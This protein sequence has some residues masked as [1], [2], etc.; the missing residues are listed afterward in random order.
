[1]EPNRFDDLSRS[2]A[3]RTSR[4]L[5]LRQVGGSGLAAGILAAVG[6]RKAAAADGDSTCK[7]TLTARVASGPDATTA[8]DGALSLT[9]TESGA[10]DKASLKTADGKRHAVVGQVTGRTVNLRV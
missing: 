5:A 1:M 9:I 7:L 2:L 3:E 8:F 6:L 10:I 4:R